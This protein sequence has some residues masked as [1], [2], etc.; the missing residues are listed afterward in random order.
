MSDSFE[1]TPESLGGPRR[2]ARAPRRSKWT[3]PNCR[4]VN[5]L[6]PDIYDDARIEY[7]RMVWIEM[8]PPCHARYERRGK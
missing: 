8:C 7:I 2:P 3:C 4:G 6:T 1:W 5:A